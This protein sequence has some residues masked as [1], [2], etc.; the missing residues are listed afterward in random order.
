MT[1]ITAWIARKVSLVL[2]PFLGGP[3]HIVLRTPH[4]LGL[5]T[6]TCLTL[7]G[8]RV[9]P[10]RVGLVCAWRIGHAGNVYAIF[11]HLAPGDGL[12]ELGRGLARP[13]HIT[14]ALAAGQWILHFTIRPCLQTG[15]HIVM[16]IGTVL[17]LSLCKIVLPKCNGEGAMIGFQ[18]DQH[19]VYPFLQTAYVFF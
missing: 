14:R 1:V 15:L 12:V 4:I 9:Q 11:N 10:K 7:M 8:I 16:P 19:S 17:D 3:L 18:S 6:A 2:D 13:L 5:V